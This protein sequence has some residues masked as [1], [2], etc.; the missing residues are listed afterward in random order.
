MKVLAVRRPFATRCGTLQSLRRGVLHSPFIAVLCMLTIE[1]GAQGMQIIELRYRLAEQVLPTLQPLVEPGGAIT[2]KDNVLFV[3]TSTANYEQIRQAVAL[4]DRAAREVLITVGQGSIADASAV[5]ARAEA[6]MG[7]G[8]AQAG[9]NRPPGEPTGI[10]V[11]AGTREQRSGV[12]TL[13]SVRTQEGQETLIS[14]GQ[15]VPFT[16]TEVAP[17]GGSSTVRQT[18]TYRNV[19]SGFYATVRLSGERVTIDIAPREERLSARGTAVHTRGVHTTVSGRLGE[20]IPI[21]GVTETAAFSS[22]SLLTEGSAVV[23]SGYRTWLKV[24]EIR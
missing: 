10:A 12:R 14:R 8:S 4:L 24:D 13:A 17:Y 7:S 21:G 3:R 16:T 5:A 22:G 2:G 18:T 23:E 19:S 1:T 11:R 6:S 15:S 9:I 20:W